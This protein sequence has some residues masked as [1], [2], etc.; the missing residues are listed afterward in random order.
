MNLKKQIKAGKE[1]AYR[2]NNRAI[3]TKMSQSAHNNNNNN[4]LIAVGLLPGGSIVV[5]VHNYEKRAKNLKPGG[6]HE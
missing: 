2:N 6:L 3:K 4:L 5:H 1:K